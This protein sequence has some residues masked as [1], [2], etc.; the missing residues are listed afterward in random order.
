MPGCRLSRP[1][2]VLAFV[3]GSV[4]LPAHAERATP[5]LDA[6]SV[7]QTTTLRAHVDRVIQPL[8][9]AQDIPGMSVAV[10]VDGRAQVF[11]YGTAGK[12]DA[13]PVDDATLF[14]IGS[15]SKPFT[16]TLGA[17]LAARHGWSMDDPASAAWPALQGTA[18]D[19][20]RM[21]D[22]ATYA[23]GGLPLQF[24]AGVSNDAQIAAYFAGWQPTYPPG[25]QRLYSNPSIGL[26]GYLA[27][28]QAPGGFAGVMTTAFLPALGLSSTYLTVPP[29]QQVNYA[30][31]VAKDDARVRVSPGPLDAEAY[32][33]KTTARDMIRFV[34]LAM[35]PPEGDATLAQA[36]RL[37]QTGFYRV[38]PV[39]Q[40]LGWEIYD[41]PVSLDTLLAGNSTPMALEPQPVTQMAL[42][43]APA[44]DRFVNKT[45][46]TR[47][48][49]AYAAFLPS[50]Q[51]GVVLLANR[52]YP[53]AERVKAAWEILHALN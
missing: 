27:A 52:N 12:D 20:I 21:R 5:A 32:G 40:G 16:G 19:G 38:G 30:W 31:G 10:T 47:G 35:D 26:F 3:L 29:E 14:E 44:P 28:R 9:A 23:A 48:F 42:A 18:F 13:R 1:F 43:Q 2:R 46:S 49:G 33:V 22:L 24:P 39:L 15:L 34:T 41:G 51:A 4:T 45:G 11:H 17:W 25:T 6:A 8:M 7:V 53:N 37:A 36:L 50:A